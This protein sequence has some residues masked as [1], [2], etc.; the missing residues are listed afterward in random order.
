MGPD[1]HLEILW[2]IPSI[3]P[4]QSHSFMAGQ[5]MPRRQK[6]Q[7]L[8]T[9]SNCS[10]CQ[11]H[12]DVMPSHACFGS[13][14]PRS[15]ETTRWWSVYRRE[16]APCENGLSML[17][18]TTLAS[19]WVFYAPSCLFY[20]SYRG[21]SL[22]AQLLLFLQFFPPSR[23]TLRLAGTLEYMQQV[24]IWLLIL[25]MMIFTPQ[26][27]SLIWI[28]M[29]IWVSCSPVSQVTASTARQSVHC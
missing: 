20:F 6:K 12:E 10:C 1:L 13:E 21:L 8:Q 18:W 24:E 23:W 26:V 25:T 17:F 15:S 2:P 16:E 28:H 14:I 19:S 22:A 11:F 3:C 7:V 5:E 4:R 27:R 29:S 9:L